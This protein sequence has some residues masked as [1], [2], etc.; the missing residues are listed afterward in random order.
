MALRE[1]AAEKAASGLPND[2][3]TRSGSVRDQS[4]ARR[5]PLVVASER[6]RCS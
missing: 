4:H 5:E 6:Q 2:R 1:H 3:H